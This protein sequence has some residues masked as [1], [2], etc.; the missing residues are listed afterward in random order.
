MTVLL[1]REQKQNGVRHKTLGL[2]QGNGVAEVIGLD[3]SQPLR[4]TVKPANIPKR[5]LYKIRLKPDSPKRI[6][7]K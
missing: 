1:Q 7:M 5:N 4:Y 6:S 2:Y 3:T